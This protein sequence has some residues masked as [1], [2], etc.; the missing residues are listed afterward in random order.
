[1]T[2]KEYNA[3]TNMLYSARD[4][5]YVLERLAVEILVED[6][7]VIIFD[8]DNSRANYLACKDKGDLQGQLLWK[9]IMN[10]QSR[11]KAMK[12]HRDQHEV[13]VGG[14]WD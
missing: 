9:I 5:A 3:V 13:N 1:M 8:L 4:S 7:D 6:K 14:A 11:I 12:Q 2:G 10:K